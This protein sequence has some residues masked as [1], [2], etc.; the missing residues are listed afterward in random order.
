MELK[1]LCKKKK[2]KNAWSFSL[3]QSSLVALSTTAARIMPY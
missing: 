1:D 3:A 2:K